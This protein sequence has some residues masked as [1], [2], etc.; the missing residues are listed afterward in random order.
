[1]VDSDTSWEEVSNWYNALT[2]KEGHYY[3][4]QVILPHLLK[5]LELENIK[6]P[7]LLDL[8][9]GQGILQRALPK[10][11]IYHGL[12]LSKTLISQAKQYNKIKTHRFTVADVTQTLPLEET[13]THACCILALQNMENPLAVCKN[14]YSHLDNHGI[15]VIVL[16]HPCFRIPRQSSWGVDSSKKLQYRRVDSYLSPL[17]IPIAAHPSKKEKSQ[18]TW[19]FHLPLSSYATC[20]VEAGFSIT[21]LEEWISPKQSIGKHAKMENRARKEF[22][23]F[24][25]IKAQKLIF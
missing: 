23:L 14:A 18:T 7:S 22:P 13:Y 8:A 25:A 17:K 2:S 10:E 4:T 24:L 9:C 11:V 5:M 20:L 16:N 1:M 6:K 12:D 15:F 3:H 21:A 19:S